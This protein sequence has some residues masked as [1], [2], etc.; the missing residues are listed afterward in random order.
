[1]TISRRI[2]IERLLS[3]FVRIEAETEEE[4]QR[5]ANAVAQELADEEFENRSTTWNLDADEEEEVR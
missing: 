5:K 2:Y 3:L 1:M 4:F